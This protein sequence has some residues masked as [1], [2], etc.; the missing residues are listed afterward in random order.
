MKNILLF[1]PDND[2]RGMIKDYYLE[3]Y[4]TDEYDNHNKFLKDGKDLSDYNLLITDAYPSVFSFVRENI[5]GKN[6]DLPVI[7]FYATWDSDQAKDIL[8]KKNIFILNKIQSKDL[9]SKI[10]EIL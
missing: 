2:I 3:D 1:E 8:N 10:K 7:F 4:Y 5:L 6:L 9:A